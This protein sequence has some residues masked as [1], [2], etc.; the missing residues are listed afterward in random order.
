MPTRRAVG[1]PA[2]AVALLAILASAH[3]HEGVMH[4]GRTD[5][6][7]IA[8]ADFDFHDLFT[9]SPASPP[10]TGW[11]GHEPI[12]ESIEADDPG[13]GIFVLD[14]AAKVS[15]EVVLFSPAVKLWNH[16]LDHSISAPGQQLTLGAL[17][18][19][20][21]TTWHV[22]ADDPAFDPLATEWTATFRLIDTGSTAYAPSEAYSLHFTIIPA[23]M[24]FM[25]VAPVALLAIRRRR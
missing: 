12:F 8:I 9:L 22:D 18:F 13:A 15:V 10:L 17:P 2:I 1:A 4:V 11:S 24:T 5:T 16:D 6:G 7:T 20:E 19:T 25:T 21:H 23:P 3:A 14:T